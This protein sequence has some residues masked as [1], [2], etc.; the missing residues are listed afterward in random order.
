MRRQGQKIWMV[1]PKWMNSLFSNLEMRTSLSLGRKIAHASSE[2][3]EF[4]ISLQEDFP[5]GKNPLKW[6]SFSEGRLCRGLGEI[7][8]IEDTSEKTIILVNRF[9]SGPMDAGIIASTWEMAT[10]KRHKFRW[11]ETRDVLMVELT[12]DEV[13][14]PS[15]QEI[16]QHWNGIEEITANPSIIQWGEARKLDTGGWEID[17]ERK[18]MIHRDLFL[19]F[20]EYS[21]AQI[22]TL[23]DSR[24]GDYVWK[25]VIGKRAIWWTAVADSCRQLFSDSERHVMISEARD[26]TNSSIR[27]LSL[28]GLGRLS[29]PK[30]NLENGE[31][32]SEIVGC[33]HP[34]IS[35]GILLG[36]WER[37]T[38]I[39]GRIKVDSK[40]GIMTVNIAPKRASVTST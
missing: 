33:F 31:L 27:N 14:I 30:L 26:W 34:A 17:G 35:G 11:S 23:T 29:N 9:S 20:E 8:I 21:L 22:T 5:R 18:I 13:A 12:V 36:C 16:E 15:P 2:S 7:E 37:S 28:Q 24:E 38:G 6:K 1:S 3:E 4:L 40:E 19:R 10:G 25:D 39:K 32:D